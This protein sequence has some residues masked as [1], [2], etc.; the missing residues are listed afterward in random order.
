VGGG[1]ILPHIPTPFPQSRH[2]TNW[3]YRPVSLGFAVQSGRCSRAAISPGILALLVT[4]PLAGQ[5]TARPYQDRYQDHQKIK[6][7]FLPAL[8]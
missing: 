8:T 3:T 1:H 5:S 6:K 7:P 2:A 4:L